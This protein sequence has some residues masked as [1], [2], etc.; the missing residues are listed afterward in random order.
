M[1]RAPNIDHRIDTL[2]FL[3]MI[4]EVSA[5]IGPVAVRFLDWP[6][7]VIAKL[8]RT[9]QR[10]SHWLPILDFLALGLFKFTV[11]DEAP[12]AQFA[13]GHIGLASFMQFGF[14][15]KQVVV[16]AKQGQVGLDHLHHFG[17]RRLTEQGKPFAFG[18][19]D[20]LV[21]K[22]FC[23]MHAHGNEIIAGIEALCDLDRFAQR[24]TI[25]Q[26]RRAGEDIDL[27]AG[28]IDIIFAN[29]AVTCKFE[30]LRQGVA[31]DRAPA[32]AHMHWT[33]WVCRDIFDIHRLA[34]TKM[35]AAIIVT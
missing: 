17:D 10:Q 5:K 11:I 25:A 14:G 24:L 26:M 1:V 3:E 9:E 27:T 31:N 20:I 29:D 28:I 22:L 8:R 4:S 35:R 2:A 18:R 7:L 23:Q 12:C 13:L 33:S 19:S 15:R 32:M 6:V 34:V 21:A 16:D 30:Q